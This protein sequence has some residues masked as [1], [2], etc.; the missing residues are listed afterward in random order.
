MPIVQIYN[1]AFDD[2]KMLYNSA[3]STITCLD[4]M[5]LHPNVQL[6]A[7]RQQHITPL[8]RWNLGTMPMDVLQ[9][10]HVS[11]LP[12]SLKMRSRVSGND[13]TVAVV[14]NCHHMFKMSDVARKYWHCNS[15][16]QSVVVEYK[17]DRNFHLYLT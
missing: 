10:C 9:I 14:D 2:W 5:L 6:R 11:C 12:P 1:I 15:N 3:S 7:G 17:V 4:R 13:V 8:G 16:F